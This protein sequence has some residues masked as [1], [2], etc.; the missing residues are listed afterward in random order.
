MKVSDE[1]MMQLVNA[2]E[3]AAY[4]VPHQKT[5]QETTLARRRAGLQAVLDMLPSDEPRS[6][7]IKIT[8]K[9]LAG[10]FVP[11]ITVHLMPD[12]VFSFAEPLGIEV[13]RLA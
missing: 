1:Q 6:I 10:V 11:S 3:R 2:Y 5:D 13:E 12:G 8:K 9:G 4:A 7:A